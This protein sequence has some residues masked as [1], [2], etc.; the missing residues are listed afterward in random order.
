MA[1]LDVRD[2][3]IAAI[4]PCLTINQLPFIYAASRPEALSGHEADL[5][6]AWIAKQNMDA[7]RMYNYMA[8]SLVERAA[9][10]S[11]GAA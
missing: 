4:R 7:Q 11:K 9:A 5:L 2:R 1:R 6:K 3:R 8:S 10:S